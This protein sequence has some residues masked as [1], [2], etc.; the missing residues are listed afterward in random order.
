MNGIESGSMIDGFIESEVA[1]GPRSL[2]EVQQGVMKRAEE[3]QQQIADLFSV[4]ID[5]VSK[6]EEWKEGLSYDPSIQIDAIAESDSAAGMHNLQTRV[7]TLDTGALETDRDEDYWKRV[8]TH[9]GV[10]ETQHVAVAQ[11]AVVD[12]EEDILLPL[13]EWH[14]I[15]ESGQPDSD[16]TPEYVSHRQKGDEIAGLIGADTIKTAL[17]EGNILGLQEK[18]AIARLREQLGLPADQEFVIAA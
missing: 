13:V 8:E 15:T 14:A 10:H 2:S 6:A 12:G 7:T 5:V 9:E 1:A 3:T 17:R 4:Q 18:I 11:G 16:L